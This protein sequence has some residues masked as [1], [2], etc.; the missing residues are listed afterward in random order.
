MNITRILNI[1]IKLLTLFGEAVKLIPV[2]PERKAERERKREER[3]Q[4]KQTK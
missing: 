4:K 1:A 2:D 3:R